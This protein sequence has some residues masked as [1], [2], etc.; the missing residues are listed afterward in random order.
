MR[1]AVDYIRN[2]HNTFMTEIHDQMR[3]LVTEDHLAIET[4]QFS[5][6][7][8]VLGTNIYKEYIH[9]RYINKSKK[10]FGRLPRVKTLVDITEEQEKKVDLRNETIKFFRKIDVARSRRYDIYKLTSCEILENSYFLTKE[11]YLRKHAKHE[12]VKEIEKY[13]SQ[14]SAKNIG[15]KENDSKEVTVID[16]KAYARTIPFKTVRFSY[17]KNLQNI[18]SIYFYQLVRIVN[19]LT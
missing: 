13:L 5:L 7:C 18:F 9:T 11:S 17:L 12:L 16:F 14:P 2:K 19:E 15:Q 8:N 4:A 1:E 6:Q 3:N 10:L